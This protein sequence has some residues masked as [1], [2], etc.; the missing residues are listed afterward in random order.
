MELRWKAP[1]TV[2]LLTDSLLDPDIPLL[3]R[4][5]I[6]SILEV[7]HNPRAVEGLYAGLHDNEFNARYSCARALARMNVRDEHMTIATSDVFKPVERET[8]VDR[9]VWVARDIGIDAD[10]PANTASAQMATDRCIDYSMEH[11]FTLFSLT[12]DSDALAL[13]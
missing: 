6:P 5:R 1:Q 12:L 8:V 13:S 7:K 9:A 2:G 11:A 3:A 4:Q 10:L